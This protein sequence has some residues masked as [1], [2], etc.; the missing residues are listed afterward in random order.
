LI[1]DRHWY[2]RPWA[3]SLAGGLLPFGS[4]FIE[5]YFVL[6]SLW[7]LYKCASMLA[8]TPTTQVIPIEKISVIR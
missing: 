2:L 1:P 8:G 3:L 5:S 4:I 7:S 6:S